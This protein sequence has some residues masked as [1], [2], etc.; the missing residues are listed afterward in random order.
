VSDNHKLEARAEGNMSAH[1]VDL[2]PLRR[3]FYVQS[4]GRAVIGS[5]VKLLGPSDPVLSGR[6]R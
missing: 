5:L 6:A 2:K 1:S 3:Y 4:N